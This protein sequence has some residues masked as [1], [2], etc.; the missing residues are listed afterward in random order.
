MPRCLPGL[1]DRMLA[2][3]GLTR[4]DVRD[5]YSEPVWRDPTAILVSRAQERRINRRRAAKR[6]S[7]R[8][9]STAPS[10]RTDAVLETRSGLNATGLLNDTAWPG[11]SPP[12]ANPIRTSSSPL[13]SGT[14]ARR[15]FRRAL[16][17]RAQRA[18]SS[19]FGVGPV[20]RGRGLAGGEGRD[21]RCDRRESLPDAA[22]RAS[23]ELVRPRC[24]ARRSRRCR[25]SPRQPPGR[26][27]RPADRIAVRRTRR[28]ARCRRSRVPS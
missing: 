2:D 9:R 23:A 16:F 6:A 12:S 27:A 18:T 22:A 17:H 1:D 26:Q 24:A 13:R 8:S 19:S 5:A 7:S 15:P 25:R 10:H 14:R 3:I 28:T 4:G 11:R 20:E 21:R